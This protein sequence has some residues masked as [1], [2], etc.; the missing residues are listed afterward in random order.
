MIRRKTNA[1]DM[2]R[3]LIA[4]QIRSQIEYRVAF[5]LD[6]VAVALTTATGFGTLALILQRFENIGGWT[7]GQVAFL[8]GIVE[9]AFGT[10]DLIFGG[11]DPDTFA[12]MVQRGLFD[13]LLLRPLGLTLQV[14]GSQFV[15]RRLSR[16]AQGV[17]V[18]CIGLALTDIRWTVWKVAYLPIVFGS[19][20]LFFGGLYIIGS[21]STFW[22]VQRIE[23]INIFTYGGSEMMSYPMHIYS[24]W[25]R[26]FFTFVVPAIFLSYY[27]ALYI[28][29]KPDPLL[30]PAFA[31]FLSP[32]VGVGT[33]LAALAFWRF[34]VRH[35]ASTGT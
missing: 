20:I 11:F 4:I 24:K 3:R 19:L 35:Y 31:P 12:P 22:T 27:P 25:M 32:L 10:M 28:L 1:L 16:V 15:M 6:L 29:D 26:R 23:V 30:M 18:F 2:Y 8:Y 9:A 33:I 21:T 14:L 13:Q 7:L 5:V 34:G 17:A